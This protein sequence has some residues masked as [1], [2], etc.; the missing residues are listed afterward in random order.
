VRKIRDGGTVTIHSDPSKKR[1]AS[2]FWLHAR[3]AAD[4][5]LYLLLE[6]EVGEKYNIVGEKEMDVLEIALQI[7]AIIGVKLEFEMVDFHSSRPGH[8]MRYALDGTKLE[9]MG[10]HFP[11]NFDESLEKTVRWMLENP[12]WL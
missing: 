1:A 6:G 4:A 11:K 7:A 3:N 2:R 8:D 10:Y 12:K 9:E 5:T